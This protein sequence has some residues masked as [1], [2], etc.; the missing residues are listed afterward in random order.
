MKQYVLMMPQDV[1]TMRG[2]IVDDRRRARGAFMSNRPPGRP[3]SRRWQSYR[4]GSVSSLK[5]TRHAVPDGLNIEILYRYAENQFDRLPSRD[6]V[7]RRVAATRSLCIS[8]RAQ[9]RRDDDAVL[10]IAVDRTGS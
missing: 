4:Y 3:R 8:Y 10:M 7:P 5:P 1:H 2:P 9:C 6:L